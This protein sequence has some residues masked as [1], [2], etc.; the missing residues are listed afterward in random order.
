MVA[1]ANQFTRYIAV[2]IVLVVDLSAIETYFGLVC[3][4]NVAIMHIN[5][6]CGT[7]F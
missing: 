5:S 2:H 1:T 4:I 3:L 6:S 7:L